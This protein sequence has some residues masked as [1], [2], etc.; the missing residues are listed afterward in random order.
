MNTKNP[1]D[2]GSVSI[3]TSILCVCCQRQ[4]AEMREYKTLVSIRVPC[5]CAPG[6]GGSILLDREQPADGGVA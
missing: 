4:V 5:G 6:V 3:R 2:D 1:A